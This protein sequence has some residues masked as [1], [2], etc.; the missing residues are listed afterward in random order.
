MLAGPGHRGQHPAAGLGDHL[1]AVAGRQPVQHLGGPPRARVGA[2]ADHGAQRAEQVDVGDVLVVPGVAQHAVDGPAGA[3]FVA[4]RGQH[5]ALREVRLVGRPQ[6]RDRAARGRVRHRLQQHAAPPPWPR[7]AGRAGTV[8]WPGCC[9][10]RCATLSGTGP[11]CARRRPAAAARWPGRAARTARS[12]R[13]RPGPAAAAP[14]RPRRRRRGR[15]CATSAARHRARRAGSAPRR[16]AR[17]ARPAPGAV[18]CRP[19]GPGQ[20][21]PQP[22]QVDEQVVAGLGG[23]PGADG[24]QVVGH[25]HLPVGQIARLAGQRHVDQR[26]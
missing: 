3:R 10:G 26:G 12:P 20:L 6:R 21:L 5:P 13:T 25:R 22:Q 24:V 7:H 1:A 23:R 8:P 16:A 9:S 2:A 18:R 17:P 4:D 15:R 19:A 11:R 14:G